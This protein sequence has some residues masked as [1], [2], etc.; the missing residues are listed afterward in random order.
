MKISNKYGLPQFLVDLIK[1]DDYDRGDCDFTITELL[2]PPRP[3]ALEKKHKDEIEIDVSEMITAFEGKI[4]HKILE[5][6]DR[7]GIKEKRFFAKIQGYTISAQ[8]DDLAWDDKDPGVLSD[9]KRAPAFKMNKV[10]ADWEFQLNGQAYIL[11]QNGINPTGLQIVAW[12]KDHSRTEARANDNYPQAP[13]LKIPIDTWS[14][15]KIENAIMERIEIH[16]KAEKELPLCTDDERFKKYNRR[17][18]KVVPLKCMIYCSTSRFCEQYQK[19][20]ENEI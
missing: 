5:S 16:V 17:F 15:E 14:K 18:G 12:G 13:I 3:R 9:W 11:R 8:L 19:E 20:K 7:A 4:L 2:K 1:N 6:A 10:D